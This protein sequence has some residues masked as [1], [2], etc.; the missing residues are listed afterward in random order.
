MKKINHMKEIEIILKILFL[1]LSIAFIAVQ[2]VFSP[3]FDLLLV[4]CIV[5]GLVL[6]FNHHVGYKIKKGSKDLLYRHIEGGILIIF[7]AVVST[8]GL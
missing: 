7:A 5:L 4:V 1:G 6:L 2:S 3:L 8:L